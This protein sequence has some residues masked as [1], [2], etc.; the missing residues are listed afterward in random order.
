MGE[1]GEGTMYNEVQG[2]WNLSPDHFL[3]FQKKF[4]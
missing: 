1:G 2:R 4:F 3:A